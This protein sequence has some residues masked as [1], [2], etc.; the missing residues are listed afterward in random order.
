MNSALP[1]AATALAGDHEEST[2]ELTARLEKA[3]ADRDAW[4]A[5]GRQERYLEAYFLA[6]G[7]QSLLFERMR[8][9]HAAHPLG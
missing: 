7:L 8:R 3:E 5:A 2:A 4:K 9:Q 1:A 6:E